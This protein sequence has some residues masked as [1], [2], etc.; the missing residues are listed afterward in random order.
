[1]IDEELKQIIGP[2]GLGTRNERGNRTLQFCQE[3]NLTIANTLFHHHNRRLYTWKSLGDRNQIDYIMVR[4]R[5]KSAILNCKTYP[6]PECGSDQL[7]MQLRLKRTTANGQRNRINISETVK[8][9]FKEEIQEEL[10]DKSTNIMNNQDPNQ[11]WEVLKDTVKK[12]ADRLQHMNGSINRPNQHWITQRTLDT[13]EERKE[14]K[15]KGKLTQ[16]ENRRLNNKIQR[17]CRQDKNN[18]IKRIC[19]EIEE[20]QNTHDT[21][22]LYK[23]VRELSRKFTPRALTIEDKDGRIIWE[24]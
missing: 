21:R 14:L 1:M 6:G 8:D 12:T 19:R 5:W 13:V 24:D 4:T 18:Y 3:H 20:H 10:T 9:R 17:Q 16:N 23:K 2:F 22:D 15:K 7:L 11:E